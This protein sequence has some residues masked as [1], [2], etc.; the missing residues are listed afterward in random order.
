MVAQVNLIFIVRD[1]E[2]PT[3]ISSGKNSNILA[4]FL[5][6]IWEYHKIREEGKIMNQKVLFLW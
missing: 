4:F 5:A 1:K 3:D 2:T 6:S